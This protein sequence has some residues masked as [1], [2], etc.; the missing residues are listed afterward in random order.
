MAGP[1]GSKYY[2]IFLRHQVELV[3]GETT[4]IN[5]EAF[6]L[7][8]EIGKGHSIVSAARNM[9]I[10]YRKAWGLI[11]DIEY[12]LGFMLVRKKRGG[13]DGGRTTFSPE[14]LELMDAYRK[15]VSE[16]ESTDKEAVKA[17]FRRLNHIS[18]KE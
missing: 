16:L 17:F 14:G 12:N 2:D 10:S 7:L 3:S 9:N 18:A 11:R 6:R 1:K 5:E 13:K 4:I 15:L 8:D